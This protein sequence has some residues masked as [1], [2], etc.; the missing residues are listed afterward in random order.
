VKFEGKN[1]TQ[2]RLMSRVKVMYL[3]EILAFFAT[4]W[5]ESPR[6]NAPKTKIGIYG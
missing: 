6:E 2:R 3:S 4:D 5:V 1:R